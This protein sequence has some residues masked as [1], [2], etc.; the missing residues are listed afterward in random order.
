MTDV[1]TARHQITVHALP[2]EVYRLISDA[3]RWPLIFEPT[4][5]VEYLSRNAAEERFRLWAC[6]DRRVRTWVSRRRLD[7]AAHR[8]EFWREESQ[9]PTASMIGEWKLEAEPGGGTR[10]TLAHEFSAIGDDPAGLDW[11]ARMTHQNSE[12]ELAGL[13]RLVDGDGISAGLTFSFEDAVRVRGR[14]GDVYGFIY[15]AARW[16]DRLPHVS[17][18]DLSEDPP[19]V[20]VMDMDTRRPDGSVHN[21]CSVRICFPTE[22]IVYKQLITPVSLRVHVGEWMFDQAGDDVVVTARHT[23]TL[24]PSGIAMAFGAATGLERARATVRE[25][26]GGNSRTTLAR[27]RSYA[28]SAAGYRRAAT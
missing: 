1:R 14:L 5:H 11:I 28:E 6:T 21:T 20:Q 22:R 24:D 25:R 23:V 8:V 4:V 26:I 7:P 12:R 19:N 17:R 10:V 18:L 27:A 16:P 2:G 13:R 9:P 3:G 15:E